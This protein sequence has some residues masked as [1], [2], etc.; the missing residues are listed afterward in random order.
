MMRILLH[1]LAWVLGR[2]LDMDTLHGMILIATARTRQHTVDRRGAI[3]PP[4]TIRRL[5]G[6]ECGPPLS[7]T[8]DGRSPSTGSAERSA[9]TGRSAS[10]PPHQAEQEVTVHGQWATLKDLLF[11]VMVRTVPLWW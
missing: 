5:R 4:V 3:S 9:R 10:T 2:Q 1:E 11:R 8:G 7:R 6:I